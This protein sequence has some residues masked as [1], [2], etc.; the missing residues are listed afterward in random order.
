MC[1]NISYNSSYCSECRPI[2]LSVKKNR[3]CF[4][5]M[6]YVSNKCGGDGTCRISGRDFCCCFIYLHRRVNISIFFRSFF[7]EG[8]LCNQ[9]SRRIHVDDNGKTWRR[10][11]KIN[12]LFRRHL[13]KT[14]PRNIRLR[15]NVSRTSY[16]TTRV[17]SPG[18]LLSV[19]CTTTA[20]NGHAAVCEKPF[21]RPARFDTWQRNSRIKFVNTFCAGENLFVVFFILIS[22]LHNRSQPL[23]RGGGGRTLHVHCALSRNDPRWSFKKPCRKRRSIFKRV[24]SL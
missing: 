22:L 13:F 10:R 14:W 12:F 20:C 8:W 6:F 18:G 17:Y 15:A 23:G 19:W 5:Y 3:E 24:S 4:T 11:K 16:I 2:F 1:S 21:P 7:W 9:P